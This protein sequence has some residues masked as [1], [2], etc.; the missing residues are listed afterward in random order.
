MYLLLTA[1]APKGSFLPNGFSSGIGWHTDILHCFRQPDFIEHSKLNFGSKYFWNVYGIWQQD[2][3]SLLQSLK[4]TDIFSS[5]IG[6]IMLTIFAETTKRAYSY[7]YLNNFVWV[8]YGKIFL[9]LNINNHN[10]TC[11][12]IF[13]LLDHG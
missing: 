7:E 2:V 6:K 5:K 8:N 11:L 12:K 13:F 3:F 10:F 9:Y 4:K 1:T